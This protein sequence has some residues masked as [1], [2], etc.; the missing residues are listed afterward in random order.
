MKGQPAD[1]SAIDAYLDGLPEDQRA[2]L[3]H[4][5]RTLRAALPGAEECFSYGLPAFRQGKLV[6]GYAAFKAHLSFYPFSETVLPEFADELD[7]QGFGH[8]KSLVR[9]T[10]NHPLPDDLIA[11]IVAARLEETAG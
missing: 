1:P 4:L 9:F 10:A 11:R 2:A 5:R 6:A 8:T 7:A 3:G